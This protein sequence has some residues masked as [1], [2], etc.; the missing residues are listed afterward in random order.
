MER[1]HVVAKPRATSTKSQLRQLRRDGYVPGVVYGRNSEPVNITVDSKDI[2]AI[3]NTPTGI[4]TLVD[5][6]VDGSKTLAIIKELQ[7]DILVPDRFIS[8]D[9]MRVSLRDK[10]EVQ[11]PVVLMGEAAGVKEGGVLQQLLREVTLK[12][13][14]TSIPEQLELDISE[15]AVGESL[16]VADLTIPEDS[17]MITDA[18]EIVV[19]VTAPRLELEEEAVEEE[20]APEEAAADA[21]VAEETQE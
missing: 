4:N 18:E 19:T 21:G 1:L 9:F 7:R 15:L 17:E 14:P 6:E 3:L 13:L 20:E 12:C 10:L 5:L 16:T 2:V 11:V 8:V